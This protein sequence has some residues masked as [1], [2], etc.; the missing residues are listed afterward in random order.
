M[1]AELEDAF[2]GGGYT[3]MQRAALLQLAWDQ[4]SSGLDGREAAFELHASGGLESW[5]RQLAAWFDDYNELA[6]AVHQP[7]QRGPATDGPDQPPGR[8]GR[9]PPNA[10]GK[11]GV[12][13][14]PNPVN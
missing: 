1:A 5:R 13:R 11:P 2:G 8:A 7:G 9:A 14:I 3:A 6:N 12:I 10:P 4:V